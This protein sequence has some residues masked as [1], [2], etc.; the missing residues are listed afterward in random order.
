MK[1]NH[2]FLLCLALTSILAVGSGCANAPPNRGFADGVSAA[3][4]PAPIRFVG[5]IMPADA[6]DDDAVK[7]LTIDDA[8]RRALKNDPAVQAAI[9]DVRAA[10]SDAR[11]ARLIPNPVL[12]VAV[13]FPD[14]G[15]KTVIEAGLT[16]DLISLLLRPRQIGAADHRLRAASSDALTTVLDALADVQERYAN[17]QAI[18]AR[19]GVLDQRKKLVQRLRDLARARLEAGESSRRDLITFDTERVSLDVEITQ[20]VSE[21]RE[22]RLILARL[23]GQP[24][25]PIE[26][27]L[28]PWT[29]PTSAVL[30]ETQWVR[31]A[32]EHRP[33]V[34]SRRWE[35]AALGDD[36]A[37]AQL[38]V[39][40]G[41]DVGLDAERD[42]EWSIGPAISTP[43]PL[44]DWGQQRR[45]KAEAERAAARHRLTQTRRQVIEQVRRAVE[46]LTASQAALRQVQTQLIPLADERVQQAEAAYKNGLVDVT[47]VLQAEQETQAARSKLI[48]LQQSVSSATYR[49]HR[50]VGGPGIAAAVPITPS[51]NPTATTQAAF[52]QT[53]HP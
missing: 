52:Q 24:S 30:D 34:Q 6:D 9:A 44:F 3:G 36:V 12:S 39:F 4:V 17:V 19:I 7:T 13:R 46:S 48:E 51:T 37:I 41:A 43:L 45:A 50:A 33:E 10:L 14:G 8:V 42:E 27:E 15:G 40:D 53:E 2:R 16:A 38:T 31:A 29:P 21:R 22:Q 26:W 5:S 11:Q 25:G 32:L 20:A 28:T 49:L 35:L 1:L 23:I 47:A 18:D